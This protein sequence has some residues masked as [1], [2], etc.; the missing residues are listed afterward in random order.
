MCNLSTGIR[1]EGI[2]IGEHKGRI[3]TTIDNIRNL[4]HTQN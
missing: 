4:M 2:R 3:E 1:E